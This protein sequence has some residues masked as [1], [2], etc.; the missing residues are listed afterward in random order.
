MERIAT[1]EQMTDQL[2]LPPQAPAEAV[3]SAAAAGAARWLRFANDGRASPEE[4]R[5][6]RAMYREY[7]ALRAQLPGMSA[8]PW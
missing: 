8:R 3:A 6:A 1:G 7:A 2:G 4:K 5:V